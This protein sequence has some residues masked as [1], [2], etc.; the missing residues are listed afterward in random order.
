M[1]TGPRALEATVVGSAR[2]SWGRALDSPTA[3]QQQQQGGLHGEPRTRRR[4]APTRSHLAPIGGRTQ[5]RTFFLRL[6]L[7]LTSSM[8][9][10]QYRYDDDGYESTWSPNTSSDMHSVLS[11]Y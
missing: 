4:I 5:Y 3:A 1:S 8:C 6:R 7:S 2:V 10:T 11:Y 9:F